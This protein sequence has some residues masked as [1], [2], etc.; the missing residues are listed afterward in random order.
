MDVT[1]FFYS[2]I[3]FYNLLFLYPLGVIDRRGSRSVKRGPQ[4]NLFPAKEAAFSKNCCIF[5]SK[6]PQTQKITPSEKL[7]G[8]Y[9]PKT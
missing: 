2:T 7:N 3:R 6:S 9:Q 4:K 1:M 5:S 8:E